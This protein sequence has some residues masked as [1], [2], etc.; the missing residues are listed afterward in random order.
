[1]RDLLKCYVS[2]RHLPGEQKQGTI[3]FAV[4]EYGIL[5]RCLAEGTRADLEV[6]AFLS[7]LRFVEHNIEVFSKK[8]LEIFTD[9]PIL[10]FI[11]NQ[12]IGSAQGFEA[13]RRE[14]KKTA[15]KIRFEVI[16]MDA[17]ANRAAGSIGD[18]PEMPAG[19][20]LKIKTFANLAIKRAADIRPDSPKI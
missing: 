5:F 6:I 14:A 15:K 3:S 17:Q 20:T 2:G 19:S 16:L 13:V 8:E 7:F 18:I 11:M 9:F 10:A 1:M 12:D 4:P